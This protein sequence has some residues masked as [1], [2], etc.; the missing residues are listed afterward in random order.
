VKEAK[1]LGIPVIGMVDTN[2]NPLEC[3]FPIPANDD[4]FKSIALIT[5]AI[6]NAIEEGI[7]ERKQMKDDETALSEEMK[8]ADEYLTADGGAAVAEA[9]VAEVAVLEAPAPTGGRARIG[10]AKPAAKPVVTETVAPEAKVAV[11]VS[12]TLPEVVAAE[13]EVVAVVAE[14]TP[15]TPAA[16]V[17]EAPAA[18]A[19]ADD[20]V[21][22]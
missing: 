7:A 21:A 12:E 2:S 14:A 15:E 22:A 3:D 10:D 17:A 9:A 11:S 16:V 5:K 18:D 13:P 6:A 1:K 20:E 4:A 19:T 8:A